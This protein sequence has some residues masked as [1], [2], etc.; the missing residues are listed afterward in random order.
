MTTN[1]VYALWPVIAAPR[2]RC[3][4]FG[5]KHR[6]A[7]ESALRWQVHRGAV[8]RKPIGPQVASLVVLLEPP[9]PLA[10]SGGRSAGVRVCV[11]VCQGGI[12]LSPVF[13]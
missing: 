3:Y 4:C 6:S 5:R 11:C 13:E 1:R 9:E 12:D 2:R 10:N 7:G 8:C